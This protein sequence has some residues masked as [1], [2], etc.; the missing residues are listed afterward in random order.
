LGLGALSDIRLKENIK[1]VGNAHGVQFYTWDWNEEGKRIANPKQP[2]FG[3]IA[4]EVAIS[5]PKHVSRG[6]DGYLRVNYTGLIKQL[7]AN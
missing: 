4:N 3:V 7:R 6:T 2:T 5:H 1:P